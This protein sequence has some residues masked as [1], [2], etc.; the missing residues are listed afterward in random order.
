MAFLQKGKVG[1][2]HAQKND[3]GKAGKGSQKNDRKGGKAGKDH[4]QKNDQLDPK[5]RPK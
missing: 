4:T 3:G 2:G 1:K 5:T